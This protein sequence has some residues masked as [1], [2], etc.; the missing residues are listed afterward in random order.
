MALLIS[1]RAYAKDELKDYYGAIEDYSKSLEL[2]PDDV[3]AYNNRVN[4]KDD[5]KDY[6]GAINDFSKAIELNS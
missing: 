5:L 3:N 1:N 2:N 6:N 4:A